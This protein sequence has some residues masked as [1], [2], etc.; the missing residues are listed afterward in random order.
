MTLKSSD[1]NPV[2]F[3]QP[4][5]SLQTKAMHNST[6]PT[7][8]SLD[9]MFLAKIK[10][11]RAIW[12]RR[13]SN[14]RFSKERWDRVKNDVVIG[15]KTGHEVAS[16]RLNLLRKHGWWSIGREIPNILVIGDADD[17]HLGV[18]GIKPYASSLLQAMDM[19][20]AGTH[21]RNSQPS[22]WFDKSGWRGDKDKNLPAFHLLATIFPKKKWYLLLDDDTYIFLE[23]F[24]RQISQPGMNDRPL[25]TGKVFLIMCMKGKLK[26]P[27]NTRGLFAHG[28]SGIVL[29][30]PAVNAMYTS[31]P[32]CIRK[33]SSCWAGDMQVALCLRD[34]NVTIQKK[35]SASG[36]SLGYEQDYNP[37]RP[38]K[39]MA[40]RRYTHKLRS[41]REPI[42]FHSIPEQEMKAMSECESK[43]IDA[44]VPM[45]YNRLRS[46]ILTLGLLPAHSAKDKKNTYYTDVFLPKEFK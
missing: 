12:T 30:A 2:L 7:H 38:T 28:G 31:I 25:Y 42:T 19:G 29:N 11:A 32:G 20:A 33:F 15:V 23:N 10:H 39:A 6:T 35:R 26:L 40:D 17:T 27:K 5:D 36:K 41:R 14:P 3:V 1:K 22:H 37:F 21:V 45:T 24:A 46:H 8:A 13:G 44:V 34:V 4:F 16:K 9:P 43:A 18:V